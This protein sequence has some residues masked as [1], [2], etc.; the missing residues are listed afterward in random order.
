MYDYKGSDSIMEAGGITQALGEMQ[1]RGRENDMKF[2][3]M[4]D[5]RNNAQMQGLTDYIKT[6]PTGTGSDTYKGTAELQRA[7][8]S[9]AQYQNNL[10]NLMMD[11]IRYC[12]G[13]TMMTMAGPS[14]LMEYMYN[15]PVTPIYEAPATG[16]LTAQ[17]P[18]IGDKLTEL[19]ETLET[20]NPE[21]IPQY[22]PLFEIT[23]PWQEQD[24]PPIG[25]I[26]GNDT[27]DTLVRIQEMV[28]NLINEISGD[29]VPEGENVRETPE[30]YFKDVASDSL[31]ALFTP[32]VLAK[33]GTMT[34]EQKSYYL[35]AYAGYLNQ[36]L[37]INIQQVNICDM[38]DS[39]YGQR[40]PDNRIE[41]NARI[42]DSPDIAKLG[43]VLDTII[44]EARHQFQHEAIE[45]PE[46]FGISQQTADIWRNNYTNYISPEDDL[47]GYF[48]QPIE[49]DA[50][51]FAEDVMD[52]SGLNIPVADKI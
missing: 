32:E 48:K 46:R 27:L 16:E 39:T 47:E 4:M 2:Q 9:L 34:L 17:H 37:G 43:R 14:A 6:I 26:Q 3:Q 13:L 18:Q 42:V 15:N 20:L 30:A 38:G 28:G 36:Y 52:L 49:Q 23:G 7:D 25:D 24:A 45:N 12:Q 33:W 22:K 41:I 5:Q 29:T 19:Q 40:T 8:E 51:G 50:R 10:N 35:G 44:H 1:M 11:N 31:K 21:E